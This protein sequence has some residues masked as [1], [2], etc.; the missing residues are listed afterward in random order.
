MARPKTSMFRRILVQTDCAFW[1]IHD[2]LDVL[3]YLGLPTLV[4]LLTGS[5]A[6][7]GI[8]RSWDFPPEVDFLIAGLICPFLVLLTFTALPLPCA[9]FAW[10]AAS[11]E[12]ATVGECF[13]L[14]RR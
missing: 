13:S 7:V 9:V 2:H 12:T 8:W 10:K 14:C 11:G 4:T 1:C 6:V 5:L 3:A